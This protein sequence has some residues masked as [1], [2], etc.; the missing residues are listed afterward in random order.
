MKHL[1]AKRPSLYLLLL[2][3]ISLIPSTSMA[4]YIISGTAQYGQD[5]EISWTA[6]MATVDSCTPNCSSN[7]SSGLSISSSN[8]SSEL[9]ISSFEWDYTPAWRNGYDATTLSSDT[10]LS[11]YDDN[12][13]L[14][15]GFQW[16]LWDEVESYIT[17]EDGSGSAVYEKYNFENTQFRY[18]GEFSVAPVDSANSLTSNTSIRVAQANSVPEPATVL[19]LGAGLIALGMRLG[20][21]RQ[22][23]TAIAST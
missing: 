6:T 10:Q 11:F 16:S 3:F 23:I 22:R 21:K 15:D 9:S 14:M 12:N 7:T 17:Y 5:A 8:T 20:L 2:P 19:L 4:L 18:Y 1:L 13:N